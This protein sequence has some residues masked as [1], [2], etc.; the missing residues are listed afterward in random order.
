LLKFLPKKFSI[1][2]QI[3]GF[4]IRDPGPEKNLSRIQ[5]SKRHRIPDPD[6]QHWNIDTILDLW[7]GE[8]PVH[9]TAAAYKV[10]ADKLVA[11]IS[12]APP[13]ASTATTSNIQQQQKRA[14]VREP[15]T[16]HGL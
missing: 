13:P 3:Y 1:C 9:P 5:G 15:W 12:D 16:M 2:S 7:G 14:A 4:G 10:L 11:M 8:D 6:P